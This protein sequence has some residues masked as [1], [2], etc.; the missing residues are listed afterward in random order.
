MMFQHLFIFKVF[1]FELLLYNLQN[2][3]QKKMFKTF[4]GK[5]FQILFLYNFFETYSVKVPC[6]I[7]WVDISVWIIELS[8]AWFEFFEFNSL[9]KKS[10]SAKK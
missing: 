5:I 10:F 3:T 9:F 1:N 6:K 7:S 4:L 8:V 2:Q